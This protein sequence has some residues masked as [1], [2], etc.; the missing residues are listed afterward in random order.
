MKYNNTVTLKDGRAC[1][2][3]NGTAEDGQAL[4][5]IFNVTHAQTDFLLTYPEEH[6]Y[7]AVSAE[8]KNSDTGQ[9]SVSESI[10]HIGA[11]ASVGL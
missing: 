1:I 6:S 3:R 8:K 9:N 10:G 5:N 7:S 2:L 11:W 4:L